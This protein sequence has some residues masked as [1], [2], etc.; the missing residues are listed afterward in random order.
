MLEILMLIFLTRKVGEIVSAKGRKAGWYKFMTVAL[1]F[2]CEI[3][4][5]IIGGVIIA[6]SRSD[7][8]AIA[9]LFALVGAVIGAITSYVIAKAV[10]PVTAMQMMPPPPPPTFG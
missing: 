8:F 4:G 5:G 1:W 2:G 10:P 7:S 9:Y 6:I 3:I